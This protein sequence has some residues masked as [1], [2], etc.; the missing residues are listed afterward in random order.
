MSC[1]VSFENTL[2]G[3]GLRH[4][5]LCMLFLSTWRL[6]HKAVSRVTLATTQ[7]LTILHRGTGCQAP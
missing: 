3:A 7:P 4:A 1:S 5:C 6:A 2:L